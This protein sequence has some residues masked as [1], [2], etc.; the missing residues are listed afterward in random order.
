[1]PPVKSAMPRRPERRSTRSGGASAT[2]PLAGTRRQLPLMRSGWVFAARCSASAVNTPDSTGLSTP[3]AKKSTIKRGRRAIASRSRRANGSSAKAA[4]RRRSATSGSGDPLEQYPC[5]P[6]R[7]E[8]G[9]L[10]EQERALC[11]RRSSGRET[12][13][14]PAISEMRASSTP[15][16]CSASAI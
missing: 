9:D 1:M 4:Q 11:G 5:P 10:R 8:D 7:A 2:P 3:I 16:C 12:Q 13:A 6:D 14:T 15:A